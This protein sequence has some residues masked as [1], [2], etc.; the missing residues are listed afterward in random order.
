MAQHTVESIAL[1]SVALSFSLVEALQKKGIL[2]DAELHALVQAA[3]RVG[4]HAGARAV[5][6]ERFPST[7]L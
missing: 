4:D 1:A 5:L 6:R 2:S 3:Y 7:P